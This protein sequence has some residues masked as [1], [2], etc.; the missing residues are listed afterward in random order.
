[1]TETAGAG[2]AKRLDELAAVTR[3]YAASAAAAFGWPSIVGGALALGALGVDLFV[4][5]R[6]PHVLYLS[7]PS[8]SLLVALASRA[9]YQRHG[10]VV[11]TSAALWTH[12]GRWPAIGLALFAAAGLTAFVLR[13]MATATVE[14][15]RALDAALAV[16]IVAFALVALPVLFARMV[17]SGADLARILVFVN[18]GIGMTLTA[19]PPTPVPG[20]DTERLGQVLAASHWMCGSVL[21]FVAIVMI[22]GG[23]REHARYR[24][25]ERRLAALRSSAA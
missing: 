22:A 9:Y 15:D 16:T 4:P 2:E 11:E 10:E 12:R 21:A 24:R 19:A 8:V 13:A 17:R 20:L 23:V 25:L 3:E 5:W 1:M 6:W 14:P 18:L 7:I